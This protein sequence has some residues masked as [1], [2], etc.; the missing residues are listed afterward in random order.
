MSMIDQKIARLWAHG[1]N[2]TRY[3]RLLGT[4]L[5]DVERRF[6]EKRLN[7]EQSAMDNLA[8]SSFP[9]TLEIPEPVSPSPPVA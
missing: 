3:R 8:V 7:E 1:N 9:S 6:I 2:I 4:P 5:P